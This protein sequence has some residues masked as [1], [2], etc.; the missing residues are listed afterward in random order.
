MGLQI[1]VLLTMVI[2]IETLETRIPVFDSFDNTPMILNYF[3]VTILTI[4][5]CMLVTTLTLFLHYV[6]EYESQN[7]SETEAKISLIFA[8]VVNVGTCNFWKIRPPKIVTELANYS[9]DRLMSIY[10]HF[11]H[12]QLSLG[13]QFLADMINRIVFILVIFVQFLTLLC[14]I[15]PALAEDLKDL[16]EQLRDL[17]E[18]N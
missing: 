13:F 6:S 14:V 17:E 16:D 11:N 9:N 4:S 2:Y 8:K 18:L 10:E 3:V 5:G 7:F 12:E 15:I 1:T